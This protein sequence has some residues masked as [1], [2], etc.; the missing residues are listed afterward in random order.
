MEK[1]TVALQ[2]ARDELLAGETVELLQ[3]SLGGGR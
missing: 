1:R 2:E 3:G